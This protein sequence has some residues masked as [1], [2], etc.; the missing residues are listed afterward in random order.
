MDNSNILETIKGLEAKSR[1]LDEE[2]REIDSTILS[3]RKIFG[4]ES[5]EFNHINESVKE[6]QIIN[7]TRHRFPADLAVFGG[8]EILPS[9]RVY[10]ALEGIGGEFRRLDLLRKAENDGLGKIAQGTFA[11]IFSKLCSRGIVIPINGRA[12][13]RNISYMKKGEYEASKQNPTP[14][15]DTGSDQ[16]KDKFPWDIS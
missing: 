12:G 8:N 1:E 4:L 6:N 3:L 2:K 16:V 13:E 5:H 11:T 10:R 15:T 7:V 14:V 9:D